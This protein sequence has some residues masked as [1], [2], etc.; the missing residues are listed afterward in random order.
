MDQPQTLSGFA[1][2][3]DDYDA[4]VL[5]QW[6]V[7]HDGVSTYDGVHDL[8]S[9]LRRR[10]IP[11]AIL[12]NSSKSSQRNAIRLRERFG[13]DTDLY[14]AVVSTAQLL[15]DSLASK[16]TAPGLD[17]C[18]VE[19]IFVVAH[20]GDEQLLDGLEVGISPVHEADAV[21]LLS[22]DPEISIDSHANWLAQA[23]ARRLTM[24][25]P[26]ADLLTVR[27]GAVF[28]GMSAVASEYVRRGGRVVNFGKPAREPYDECSRL[29][30]LQGAGS[31]VL[32][33]GDQVASDVV[34]AVAYGWDAALV[35]TGAGRRSWVAAQHEAEAG[36]SVPRFLAESLR[37]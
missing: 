32:A 36:R 33:V 18:G 3:L 16:K 2:I 1:E 22:V 4:I 31:R 14:S 8:L 28:T 20:E 26:S 21:V 27:P 6:G 5:D 19:R 30:G 11:V 37:L 13:I 24:L 15:R 10:A 25:V 35:M 17:G 29:L 34:G 7:L 23:A 9:Y 12:T